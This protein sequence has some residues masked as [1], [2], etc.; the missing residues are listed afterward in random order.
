[1]FLLHTRTLNAITSRFAAVAAQ[2]EPDLPMDPMAP[3]Q[4]K[5]SSFDMDGLDPGALEEQR[6][7]MEQIER[8]KNLDLCHFCNRGISPEDETVLLQTTECFH[9]VHLQCFKQSAKNALRTN[10]ALHC[11]QPDCLKQINVSEMRNY[12]SQDEIE[13]IEKGQME[14]FMN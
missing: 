12:L 8:M 7:I 11:P 1:M 3:L 14:L 13:E 5:S 6:R 4:K 9:S 2:P 10:T